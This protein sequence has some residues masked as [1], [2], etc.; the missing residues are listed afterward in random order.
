MLLS[1]RDGTCTTTGLRLTDSRKSVHKEFG[2]KKPGAQCTGSR[3]EDG[4]MLT[5][6]KHKDRLRVERKC[7]FNNSRRLVAKEKE[8]GSG[9]TTDEEEPQ[10]LTT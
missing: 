2:A 1:E 5:D 8:G 3:V 6:Q 4:L 9:R 7:R 10:N